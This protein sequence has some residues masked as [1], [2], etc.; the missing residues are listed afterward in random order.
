MNFSF[1]LRIS[2][3][4]NS[5]ELAEDL[6]AVADAEHEAALRRMRAHRVHDRRSRRDC[7]TAQVIAIGEAAGHDHEIGTVRQR[8]IRVPDHRRIAARG[9]LQRPRHVAFAID[10]GKNEDGGFH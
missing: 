9:E 7:A 5:P 4:G 3:P 1:A 2:T 10:A 6:K 8:S